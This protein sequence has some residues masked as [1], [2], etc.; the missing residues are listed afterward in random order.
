MAL[1][2]DF[3]N[4]YINQGNQDV[5][6]I[7]D[8]QKNNQLAQLKV[9]QDAAIG[10]INQQKTVTQKDYY[11]KKNQA[12]VTNA[13]N[14]Q[15][16]RELMASSGI[17]TSGDNLTLN[18]RANSD[19]MNSLNA[20]N[21]QEQAKMNEYEGQ[22]TDWNNPAREQS[23]VNQIETERSKAL[24]DAQNAAREKAWREYQFELERQQAAAARTRTVSRATTASK[25]TPIAQ[26]FR[27]DQANSQQSTLDK[28]YAAQSAMLNQGRS[29][30]QRKL[31]DIYPGTIPAP[32]NNPNLS[33]WERNKLIIDSMSGK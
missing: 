19:R 8:M 9:Q 30:A 7:Y 31:E 11:D 24:L 5:N 20:L 10:K 33:L 25:S 12:D 4:K 22:I 14:V 21:Q 27:A 13:Q 18:A 28:Y 16:L 3:E 2:S 29:L 26:Q 15:R 6:K 1:L 17:S 32:K 23:I